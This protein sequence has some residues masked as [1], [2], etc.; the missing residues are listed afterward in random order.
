MAHAIAPGRYAWI[1]MARGTALLNGATRLA[2]G[3]GAA[4]GEEQSVSLRG[5]ENMEALVFDLP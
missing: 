4:L 5:V 2:A 1:Q 3:D